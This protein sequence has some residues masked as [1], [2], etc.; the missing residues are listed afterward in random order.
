MDK[1]P[2]L[3]DKI[4]ELRDLFNSTIVYKQTV[5]N[6][7]NVGNWDKICSGLDNIEDTQ[8]AISEYT[9]L[10]KFSRL[11][12][13]GLLQSLVVQQDSLKSIEESLGIK[14]PN[15]KTSFPKLKEIRDIRN[16]TTGH[17]TETK[18]DKNSNFESGTVSYT[19]IARIDSIEIL[20]Y[21]VWSSQGFIHKSIN[22]RDII[23]IQQE[24]LILEIDRVIKKI[25]TD[26]MNHKQKF[27]DK[28][29]SSLLSQTQYHIQKL[30]SFEREREYSQ[31]NFKFLQKVYAKFKEEIQKRYMINK[32][33][34]HGV[35]IPGLIEE[36]KK[37]D[38]LL[39]RIE[40]MILLEDGIDTFDL[41]VYVE[42]LSHSFDQL[43]IMAKEIDTEFSQQ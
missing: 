14:V 2:D 5:W 3:L 30:W 29:L 13:Y 33:D 31:I 24:L 23:K 15:L 37:I 17:P 40:K 43:R 16:E 22:L 42:S 11:A 41:D 39:P 27:R 8:L 35:Q 4:L 20:D 19:T 38:I 18:L 9:R 32:V 6:N 28:S 36:F 21:G 12:L 25:K 34:E 26:E 10:E 1:N 7:K